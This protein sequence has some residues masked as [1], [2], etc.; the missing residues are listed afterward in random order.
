MRLRTFL[1]S[2][3]IAALAAPSLA[4]SGG[5]FSLEP[6]PTPTPTQGN[7]VQG[8]VDTDGPIPVR[9]RAI[10]TPSPSRAA[11]Q[12]APQTQT[13]VRPPRPEPAIP[14]TAPRP[15][16]VRAPSTVEPPASRVSD[17]TSTAE[18]ASVDT[19][20]DAPGIDEPAALETAE[21]G[22]SVETPVPQPVPT[23]AD[24]PSGEED[25]GFSAILVTAA[26]LV[27][28]ILVGAVV[29]RRRRRSDP[30]TEFVPPI[31]APRS[32]RARLKMEVA[33]LRM[34][35]S[36]MNV[37]VAYRI[38]LHNPSARALSNLVIE[39]DLVSA[40][41]DTHLD[42][43][44]ASP[45]APLP[46]RHQADRIAP[47]GSQ[48]FEGQLRLA[49]SEVTAIRQGNVAL[50]VPLMRVRALADEV[51]PVVTTLVIGQGSGARPQPFRLDEGP[52]SFAPLA[53]RK[54]DS[55]PVAV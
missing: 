25:S 44:L 41:R 45:D 14:T 10:V 6:G 50:L 30:V 19:P 38:T 52:R 47:G 8:P 13:P 4:Q 37:T 54:L 31:V 36:L 24:E 32:E 29:F 27:L 21:A 49:L 43:Q 9:P 26:A 28:A 12:E 18:Q 22:A 48:R 40:A 17:G 16:P 23:P 34:D 46:L 7:S 20:I 2:S 3:L 11:P 42:S 33:A 53:Q 39:G 15:A 55:A 1:L 35:R 51:D 5:G